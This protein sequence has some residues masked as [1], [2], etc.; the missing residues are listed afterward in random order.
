MSTSLQNTVTLK[1]KSPQELAV[2]LTWNR[3]I[4]HYLLTKAYTQ[5]LFTPFTLCVS[6][7][8]RAAC[9][10]LTALTMYTWSITGAPS[11]HLLPS[12]KRVVLSPQCTGHCVP[13]HTCHDSSPN[14]VATV[15]YL[16]QPDCTTTH[17]HLHTWQLC[18]HS[19]LSKR[20]ISHYLWAP[21]TTKDKRGQ[22]EP[23][24]ER[25]KR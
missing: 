6:K 9:L 3:G 24:V 17:P 21:R 4:S 19:W 18:A 16:M 23:L 5:P 2:N 25:K 1:F 22:E 15:N 7:W 13:L 10:Y 8:I 12:W 11:F 14:S 20:R